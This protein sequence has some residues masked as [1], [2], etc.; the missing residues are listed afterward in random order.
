MKAALS[1]VIRFIGRGS[2][3]SHPLL[4]NRPSQIDGSGRKTIS[5]PD[6]RGVAARRGR[7][8]LDL[9]RD[10]LRLAGGP[11]DHALAEGVAPGDLEVAR[12]RLAPP[13]VADDL[14]GRPVG[15]AQQDGEQLDRPT[16]RRRAGRSGAAGWS[17]CRRRPGRRPRPPG[18]A[19]RG[20]ATGRAGPSR[21]GGSR[22]GS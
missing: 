20:R 6:G 14:Q 9:G 21:P 15:L 4:A 11:V 18:R 17:P 19:P 1:Q 5:R 10:L 3:W 2:S 7:D 16:C 13:V 22:D 8:L 12:Q